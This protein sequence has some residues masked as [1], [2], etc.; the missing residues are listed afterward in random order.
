MFDGLKGF[1]TCPYRH[2]QPAEGPWAE[3]GSSSSGCRII[4]FCPILLP[5][6]VLEAFG[7]WPWPQ[8][9]PGPH[10]RLA[11]GLGDVQAVSSERVVQGAPGRGL[12]TQQ[13]N[14]R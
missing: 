8:L 6:H 14:A 2:R 7:L 12:V 10:H 13:I 1:F 4:E 11:R 3:W 5:A 9:V